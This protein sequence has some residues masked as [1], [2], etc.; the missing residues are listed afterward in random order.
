VTAEIRQRA[1]DGFRYHVHRL[2]LRLLLRTNMQSSKSKSRALRPC[3][4]L[5]CRHRII[6]SSPRL[7]LTR[8]GILAPPHRFGLSHRP[9]ILCH[10]TS[11]SLNP[12]IRTLV[13]QVSP[14]IHRKQHQSKA[15]RSQQ[16]SGRL[17]P[18]RRPPLVILAGKPLIMA[19]QLSRQLN[20]STSASLRLSH[21]LS[22]LTPR[23]S[24]LST[25]HH[26]EDLPLT[27]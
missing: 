25:L 16:M 14:R 19:R 4:H 15:S 21:R 3:L 24:F 11:A 1:Q 5:Q 26:D 9:R 18:I 22:N 17:L 2:L 13:M 8:T 6:L 27:N 10:S 23:S 7:S 12:I 20:P